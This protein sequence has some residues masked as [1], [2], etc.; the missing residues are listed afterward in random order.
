MIDIR[1]RWAAGSTYEYFMGR[2]SRS[3]APLASHTFHLDLGGMA[4]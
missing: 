4:A 2:W 3:L 1:D